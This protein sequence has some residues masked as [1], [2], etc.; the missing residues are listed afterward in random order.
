MSEENLE[1]LRR[2]YEAMNRGD[3]QGVVAYV[4]PDFE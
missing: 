2:A 4:A 3:L 1:A